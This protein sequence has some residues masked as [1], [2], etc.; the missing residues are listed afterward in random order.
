[1]DGYTFPKLVGADEFY[2]GDDNFVTDKTLSTF[3]ANEIMMSMVNYAQEEA[4]ARKGHNVIVTMG[5]DW[6]YQNA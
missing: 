5:G 6:S 1:M 3:N 2:E 4:N